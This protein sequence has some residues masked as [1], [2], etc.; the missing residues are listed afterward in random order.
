MGAADFRVGGRIFATLAAQ[1][2]GYGN[3][4][5]TPE[6]QAEFV[7][8]EPGFSAYPGGW[9]SN[10]ATH[11]V[12]AKANEHLLAGALCVAWSCDKRRMREAGPKRGASVAQVGGEEIR[13]KEKPNEAARR[14]LRLPNPFSLHGL[15][16]THGRFGGFPG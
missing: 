10:G 11:V 5:I 2:Q 15:Y 7:E 16:S 6:M 13:R 9:G 4:M 8:A 14:R 1:S 12:L 3:P